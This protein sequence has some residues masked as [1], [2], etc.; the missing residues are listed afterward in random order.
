MRKCYF[1]PT[2]HH[3]A[4]FISTSQPFASVTSPSQ[5][6][7]TTKHRFGTLFGERALAARRALPP[8]FHLSHHPSNTTTPHHIIMTNSIRA[9]TAPDA[10]QQ[11]EQREQI[12]TEDL[13]TSRE[14]LWAQSQALAERSR[15]RTALGNK[16]GA[17]QDAKRALALFPTRPEVRDRASTR[18]DGHGDADAA[19]LA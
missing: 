5:L 3:F 2:S 18:R 15:I 9:T 7:R 8:F 11:L 12:I 19:L 17:L 16:L 14:K 1:A 10:T 4:P 6:L 13:K